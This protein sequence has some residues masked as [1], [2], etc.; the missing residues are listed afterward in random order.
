MSDCTFAQ[1]TEDWSV[2]GREIANMKAPNAA[3]PEPEIAEFRY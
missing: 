2:T 3:V 1:I